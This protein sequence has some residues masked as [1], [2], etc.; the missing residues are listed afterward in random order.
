MPGFTEAVSDEMGQIIESL[1]QQRRF[2]RYATFGLNDGQV[3]ATP[4]A[5]ELYLAAIISHLTHVE[6]FWC[7]IARSEAKPI[8]PTNIDRGFNP[9]EGL[10]L[11]VLLAAYESAAGKTD[12]ALLAHKPDHQVPIPADVPWFPKNNDFWTLRW[13]ALHMVEETARHAGH[14][15]II[16]ESIDGATWLPLLSAIEGIDFGPWIKPWEAKVQA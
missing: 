11:H 9:D 1:K 12:D 13:I 6:R 4:T 8:D 10:T 14:A 16:R 7:S 3:R 15:D 2:L 5:S